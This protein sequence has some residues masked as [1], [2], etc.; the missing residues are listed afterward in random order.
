MCQ[1]PSINNWM[2][3]IL[4]SPQ[5]QFEFHCW[6][7]SPYCQHNNTQCNGKYWNH[8]HNAAHLISLRESVILPFIFPNDLTVLSIFILTFSSCYVKFLRLD[9]KWLF[10]SNLLKLNNRLPLPSLRSSSSHSH[11]HSWA[12]IHLGASFSHF[13]FIRLEIPD[14]RTST[15]ISKYGKTGNWKNGVKFNFLLVAIK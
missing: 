12:A 15:F 1:P 2:K 5:L 8:I 11:S 3:K 9:W 7:P 6:T 10:P 4:V 14:E 13:F